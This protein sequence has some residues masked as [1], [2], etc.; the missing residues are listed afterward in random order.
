MICRSQ[1]VRKKNVARNGV[2]LHEAVQYSNDLLV[3]LLLDAFTRIIFDHYLIEKYK[4]QSYDDKHANN[5][6]APSFLEQAII[7][8]IYIPYS[9]FST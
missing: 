9:Q 5:E 1:L 2:I 6:S 8:S 7:S 4:S 3:N